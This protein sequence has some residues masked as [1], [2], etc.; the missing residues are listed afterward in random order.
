MQALLIYVSMYGNCACKSCKY[1]PEITHM[2][3][4]V[5]TWVMARYLF[6]SPH[7]NCLYHVIDTRNDTRHRIFLETYMVPVS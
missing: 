1:D 3:Y 7:F 6:W 5:Q 4:I 2:K